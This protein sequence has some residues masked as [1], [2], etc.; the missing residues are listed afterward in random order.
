MSRVSRIVNN[1]HR[2]S[3]MANR[4]VSVIKITSQIFDIAC[5]SFINDLTRAFEIVQNYSN[6]VDAYGYNTFTRVE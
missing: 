3:T 2:C 5:K 4:A 6:H 1:L